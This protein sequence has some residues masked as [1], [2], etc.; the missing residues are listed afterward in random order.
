[1]PIFRSFIPLRNPWGFGAADYVELLLAVL[2][3]LL[4]IGRPHLEPWVRRIAERTGLCMLLFAVLPVL[5]RLAL[6]PHFRVPTPTGSDD[7]SHLLVADTLAHLRLANPP[8][9]FHR[10]FEAIYVM[11]EPSYSSMYPPGQGLLLAI[12]RLFGHPWA[13]VLL[14]GAAFC[15]GCYW[16]LRAWTTPVLAFAGGL[17]AVY[18]FGPMNQWMNTYWAN[19]IP[20]LAGC[21]VFGSI[22]R[23]G[24]RYAILLGLGIAL[25]LITRPFETILL[26]LAAMLFLWFLDAQMRRRLMVQA[27]APVLL[28]CLPAVALLLFQN[29]AVTGNW[30]TLP[31]VESRYQYG[32]PATFVFQP[33]PSPHRPLTPEQDLDYRAQSA[34]H[35]DEPETLRTFLERLGY[36]VRYYRF[37]FLPPLYV[38][39][40]TFLLTIRERRYLWVLASVAI[41]ALA[42]NLYPYFYPHYVGA[43]TCL[44][45][46]MSVVGLSR[47]ENWRPQWNLGRLLFILCTAQFLFWYG[48]RLS[49]QEALF[50]A[51]ALDE[52]DYVNHGDPEGRIAVNAALA[53]APGKQLVFVRY[54]PQHRFHEW[55]HNDAD[56]DAARVVWALDLGDAENDKLMRYYPDRRCWIAEPD[57][58]PVRLMPY[59]AAGSNSNP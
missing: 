4:Y 14:T 11:Q 21:L 10:F 52:W 35:G 53:K 13:G 30:T 27:A 23:N 3:L 1:M 37:F 34:I 58:Q 42:S 19:A 24:R 25:H 50:P 48:I 57:A 5:L 8:H 56:I 15:A 9:P 16:M 28:M 39:Q 12:G 55:I 36:R 17:L 59:T 44:F 46:L 40:I 49:G 33:N 26:V 6:L 18:Q 54:A 22:G 20:A 45:V 43:V 38:A 51:L 47:L 7:F 2:L 31:Y 32:V 41:F 29:K